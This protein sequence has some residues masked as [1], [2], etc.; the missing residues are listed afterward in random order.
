MKVLIHADPARALDCTAGLLA[1]RLQRQPDAVLGL[2]TGGTMEAVYARLIA[3]YKRGEVS[4][5][6]ARSFNLDEYVGVAPDHPASYWHYMREHLLDHVDIAPGAALLPRGDT[7]NPEAEAA[8]YERAIVEA[9]DIGLQLLGLGANGHIGFNEPTSS[10]ASLTRVKTLT[11]STREANARFFEDPAQVPRLAITMGIGTILRADEVL[12]LAYGE[13][14]ADAARAMIE[15]PLSAACPASA[16]QL[17]RKATVVLDAAA[18]SKLALRDYY[19][20]VHPDG[21]DVPI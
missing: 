18:A 4:F 20:E 19:E 3:A 16:L 14:K 12:L 5:G 10:L 2:A 9:G 8:T 21:R 15:G 13:G 17:H 6:Q 11:R 1:A 7:P